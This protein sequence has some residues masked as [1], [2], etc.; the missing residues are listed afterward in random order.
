MRRSGKLKPNESATNHSNARALSEASA[1]R[2]RLVERPQINGVR[3]VCRER[4]A[5]W[6]GASRQ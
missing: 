5:A 3:I 1:E 2:D 6:Q 4:K